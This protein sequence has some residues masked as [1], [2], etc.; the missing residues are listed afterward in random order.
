MDLGRRSTH[1]ATLALAAA[2]AVAAPSASAQDTGV[3]VDLHFGTA[4]QPDGIFLR[5]C[6]PDGTSWL[7]SERKRTPSGNLYL[8]PP[9]IPEPQPLA[10]TEWLY[11]GTLGLGYLGV[12]SEQATNW[13]RYNNW[14]DG[15]IGRLWLSL[16]RPNDGSYLDLQ[17]DHVNSDN[18]Y[19][20]VN[21]G[22]AGQFRFEAFGRSSVNVTSG[23]ARPIWSGIGSSYLS[24]R[25]GLTPGG[26]TPAEVAAASASAPEQ[27][28]KVVR[29]KYGVSL[30]YFID[31]Q[32][33]SYAV[34]TYEKREGAR[35]FGGPFFFAFVFPGSGGVYE[36]PRPIDD[37]TT[38]LSAGLRYAS[39]TWNWDIGYNGS[40]FRNGGS[41]FNYEVPFA[42]A[43]L[44][45]GF[46]NYPTK[47]GEFAYEPEN[48]YHNL[49][50]N[51]TRKL[52]YNGQFTLS[53]SVS[54][55]S[56]DDDLR[57]PMN[58]SG[59]MGLNVAPFTFEC[60]AWNSTAALSQQSADVRIDSTLVNAK[61]VMQPTAV[62]TVQGNLKY[63]RQKYKGSYTA[64]NPSTGQY[65]YIAENGAQGGSVPFE[66]GV[67]DATLF[68]SVVT[69]IRSLPLDKDIY[70]AGAAVDWRI[71]PKNTVGAALTLSRTERANREVENQDDALLKLNWTSY[72]VEDLTLR[73]SYSYLDRKG[74]DYN[75][76]PYEFTFSTSLPGFVDDGNVAPHT[77]EALRKFD[78]GG[79]REHKAT[80]IATYAMPHSM[81]LSGT[82]NGTWNDYDADYG[83]QGYDTWGGSLQW[84]WQ[85]SDRTTINAF[86]GFDRSTIDQSNINE[87]AAFGNEAWIG[88]DT[89]IEAN[90]WFVEDEQRNYYAGTQ[91]SHTFGLGRIDLGWN[92]SSSKGNT[93]YSFNSPSA[94]AYP[95]LA[96]MAGTGFSPMLYRVNTYAFTWTI[97]VN[98]RTAVRLFN[99]YETGQLSDWHYLGLDQG[100]V[101]DNRVYLDSGPGNY[102]VNMVG[103]MLE[104]QL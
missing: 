48:D 27:T 100:L 30:N 98:K 50:G 96:A 63:F 19:F 8:C 53:A 16:T 36:T 51:L 90:R 94:L 18:Q 76:D 52:P 45:P 35:P 44:V 23:A 28:L 104:L 84:D 61:L 79:R 2:L 43:A 34:A 60:A 97:P 85:P 54:T 39:T 56:Q 88:G 70:E 87:L 73:A 24:L 29:D 66:M 58:C 83:R 31:R 92:Y 93:N 77:L 3:G 71:S 21:G 95:A 38:N 41:H 62:V 65:G 91:V 40:L 11:R 7:I 26:S 59:L 89:Y 5:G 10:E 9:D 49:R 46:G 101:L 55:S 69:R 86:V 17:A 4:L 64:Y 82:L 13:L 47:V 80:L 102:S 42:Y 15:F 74:R 57:P 67:W 103:L 12:N 37:N 32:L 99:V 72:A 6:A 33:T 20:D 14:G 78:V 25:P 81:T 68:P 22:R 75:Y 1:H